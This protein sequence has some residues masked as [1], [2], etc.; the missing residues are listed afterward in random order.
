[1]ADRTEQEGQQDERD[2]TVREYHQLSADV[3]LTGTEEGE[4]T[5]ETVPSPACIYYCFIYLFLQRDFVRN[6]QGFF[7]YSC[8]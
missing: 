3:G 6:S 8:V 4:D 7:I 5:T 2:Q 1:M